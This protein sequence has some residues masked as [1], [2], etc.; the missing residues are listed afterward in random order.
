VHV[1]PSATGL[2]VHNDTEAG[3][4][5]F[6]VDAAAAALVD[7]APCADTSASC[8]RL[9][10]GGPHLVPTSRILGY[11]DASRE[12]IFY[13]WHVVRAQ[14]GKTRADVVHSTHVRLAE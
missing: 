9:A 1:A 4:A 8:V 3:I 5:Y 2:V 6:A 14:D 7:W 11:T 10:P 12:V 13:W